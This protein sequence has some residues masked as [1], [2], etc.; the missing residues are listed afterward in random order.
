M[1]N[2]HT[3]MLYMHPR[4]LRRIGKIIKIL[5]MCDTRQYREK[6]LKMMS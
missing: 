3:Y 1:S 2:T 4:K 6:T 5:G